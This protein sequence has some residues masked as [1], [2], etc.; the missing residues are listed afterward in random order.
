MKLKLTTKI[1]PIGQTPSDLLSWSYYLRP[2][3]MQRTVAQMIGSISCLWSAKPELRS[4]TR[5]VV[6]TGSSKFG[7]AV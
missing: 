1:Y 3:S 5:F 2:T 4:T 6:P 7:G